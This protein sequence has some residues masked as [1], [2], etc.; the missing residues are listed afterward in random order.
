MAVASTTKDERK[1]RKET[2]PEGKSGSRGSNIGGHSKETA[3][4]HAGGGGEDHVGL[5]V[6]KV[7]EVN[8]VR[9]LHKMGSKGRRPIKCQVKTGSFPS[10][11][12]EQIA[13][14]RARRMGKSRTIFV[15]GSK[16]K[17]DLVH[18]RAVLVPQNRRVLADRPD[19]VH[20]GAG[21]R[22]IDSDELDDNDSDAL[23][24]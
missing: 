10:S 14:A 3:R 21:R 11:N 19:R 15:V 9:A 12:K 24:G 5:A 1:E 6:A 18:R 13:A 16:R 22:V 17:A 23:A 4:L 20:L 2:P 7:A 8:L